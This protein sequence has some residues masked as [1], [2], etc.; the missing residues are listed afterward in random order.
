MT[1]AEIEGFRQSLATVRGRHSIFLVN[2]TTHQQKD[3]IYAKINIYLTNVGIL[4]GE[5]VEVTYYPVHNLIARGPRGILE[6]YSSN[7]QGVEVSYYPLDNLT[8]RGPRNILERYSSNKQGVEVSYYPVHN[9]TAG[10]PRGIL[11]RYYNNK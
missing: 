6:K 5:G 7:E 3:C 2:P 9:L 11:E 10:G 4:Q 1:H 8:A